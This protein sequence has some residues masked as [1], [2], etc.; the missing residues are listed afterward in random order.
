MVGFIFGGKTGRSYEELQQ[1]RATADALAAQIMGKLPTTALGGVGALLGGI[2]AGV[3]RY[4]ADKGMKE[5]R[6]GANSAYDSFFSKI[7]GGGSAAPSAPGASS[8]ANAGKMPMPGAA[9]EV[10]ATSPVVGDTYAPFMDTIKAG[11]IDNPYALAAIA[12]T[13]RAESGWSGK[14]AVSTWSDPSESGQAGTSGGIMSWRGPRYQALAATGDLSPEGQAKFF[15]NENPK[16]IESLKGA[17]SVEEA[18]QMMNNAWAFAGYNRPGGES[19]RRLGYA[20]GYLSNFQGGGGTEVASLDPSVGMPPAAA[21]IEQ[22][23]PASGYVDPMVSA[24]NAQRPVM[25]GGTGA[26]QVQQPQAPQQAPQQVAQNGQ[27]PAPPQAPSAPQAPQPQANPYQGVDPEMLKLLSNPFL[28]ADKKQ[29]IQGIMQQQMQRNDPQYQLE[30]ETKRAQLDALRAKP[31]KQWQKLD[32]YTLFNP[33]TGET[34]RVGDGTGKRQPLINAGS[35]Q[36]YDPNTQKWISSDGPADNNG[37]FRFGGKSVEAQA[38]NGLMDSGQLTEGQAQQLGAGKTITGPNGEIMFMT[39]QGV[40]GRSPDGSVSP[41][42]GQQSGGVDIFGDRPMTLPNSGA[43]PPSPPQPPQPRQQP[44]QQSG[45]IPLT[46]PKVTL[47]E[48]KAMTFADRMNQSGALIDQHGTAGANLIDKAA[49]NLP[50]GMGNYVV[51][52]EF[53]NLDQARRDFINAQLRRESGAVIADEEFDNANKQ[54]FPQPGDNAETIEQKRRNRQTVIDGMSRDGGP[55]YERPQSA[56][57]SADIARPSTEA[58]Y[59]SLPSG[60][61]FID[62]DDGKQ[63]RK[64]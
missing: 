1:Q 40:F 52:D 18:Q 54:Y 43:Q 59:N 16:L 13:G 60:A 51:S 2:G 25:G 41:I 45:M 63:Y 42:G 37:Q 24:P 29:I 53:Q 23:A 38:L 11:G 62:P 61:L 49:S 19:S 10:A 55:T 47:D 3:G 39:P 7:M 15:L 58:E 36:I 64:P 48:K 9:S 32:D 30:M 34:Q 26:P 28:D 22:Q 44:P 6:E 57:R 21:A 5:G 50:W 35:G 27:F 17:K 8:T 56:Q 33:E 46:D 4:S 12:A 20:K 31:T 14:K